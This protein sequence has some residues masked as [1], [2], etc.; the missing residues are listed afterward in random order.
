MTERDG[1]TPRFEFLSSV[2]GAFVAGAAASRDDLVAAL[3]AAPVA[4]LDL[5]EPSEADLEMLE[6]GLG[7]HG[8]AVEDVRRGGQRPKL[9]LYADHAALVGFEAVAGGGALREIHIIVAPRYCITVHWVASPAL[10][11]ARRALQ[12]VSATGDD[13]GPI[14]HAILD[15]LVDGYLPIADD[16]AN[17]VEAIEDAVLTPGD[18]TVLRRI[19]G[20]RRELLEFR[21][22]VAPQREVVNAILR[23]DVEWLDPRVQPFMQDVYDHL[24]RVLENLE[25]SRDVLAGAIEAHLSVASNDLN[26][27]MKRLTALTVVLMA[28]TL[29]AGVYGMNFRWMPELGS[30]IGYPLTLGLMIVTMALIVVYFRRREWL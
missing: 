24:I 17:R 14:V 22:V 13:P 8:L 19:L 29:I 28:P 10:L 25:F 20:L 11:N 27:V 3:G 16:L 15:A 18:P 9:D 12:R 26:A 23:G 5:S 1:A 30:P 21:S 4:W 6:R 7:I 2:D